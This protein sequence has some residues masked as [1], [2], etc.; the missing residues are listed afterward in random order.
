VKKL[1]S[2]QACLLTV[3]APARMTASTGLD[4]VRHPLLSN[5][6]REYHDAVLV[7]S[8][9]MLGQANYDGSTD[10][11]NGGG[12][13]VECRLKTIPAQAFKPKPYGLHQTHGNGNEWAGSS[14]VSQSL[15]SRTRFAG[16]VHII[17]ESFLFSA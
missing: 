9:I 16:H 13:K 8:T 15:H 4:G 7:G 5:A 3:I 17:L 11:Y 10:A 14:P 6:E 1:W 2:A 12:K